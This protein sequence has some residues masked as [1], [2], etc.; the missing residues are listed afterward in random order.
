MN[1]FVLPIIT[2][3]KQLPFYVYSVGGMVNQTPIR[4]LHGYPHYVW[5]HTIRGAGK[6]LLNGV[7][8]SLTE[9]SGLL[10][11]PESSY[12]YS[13]VE[14]PWETHWVAFSGHAVGSFLQQTGLHSSQV[15]KHINLQLLDRLINDIYVSALSNHPDSGL[16]SSGKLY[17]F[18]IELSRSVN[19]EHYETSSSTYHRLQPVLSHIEAHLSEDI[20]LDQLAEIIRVSPQYLCRLFKQSLQMSPVMYLIRLR[21][22]KAKEL[23]LDQEELSVADIGSRVGFQAPSYFC[24]V[25]KQHEGM[26]PLEYRKYYK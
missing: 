24:A 16:L 10:L 5:L 17:S 9:Q 8:H 13:A 19:Q 12:V 23:L 4:R 15:F 2:S 26:T 1:K 3:E 7:E 14:E 25:F 21:L 22:Q 11:Y 6:L 20:S 18:L